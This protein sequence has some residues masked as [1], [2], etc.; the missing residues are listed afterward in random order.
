MTFGEK[1]RNLR[2]NRNLTQA[3]AAELCNVSSR[4][5]AY[6]ETGERLPARPEIIQDILKAFGVSFEY[7]FTSEEAFE[8]EATQK[9]GSIGNKQA[10]A[11]LKN[12]DMMFAGGEL[13]EDAKDEMFRMLTE[14]YFEAKKKSKEKYGKKDK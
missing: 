2:E 9:Y 6:Y 3:E 7:L 1:L 5:F 11:I 14:L 10:Q 8:L 4:M 12:A 13:D